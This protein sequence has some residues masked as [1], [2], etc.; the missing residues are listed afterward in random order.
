MVQIESSCECLLRQT[1]H[2]HLADEERLDVVNVLLLC[3]SS[4]LPP[5]N[6]SCDLFIPLPTE[7]P[8]RFK[9][10]VTLR[11]FSLM[12]SSYSFPLSLVDDDEH[13]F[14]R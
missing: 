5:V 8:A 11:T 3:T 7:E 2:V 13:S 6:S 14:I 4:L 9:L 10:D 12:M 1:K